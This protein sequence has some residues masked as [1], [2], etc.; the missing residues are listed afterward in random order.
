MSQGCAL[1]IKFQSLISFVSLCE[2]CPPNLVFHFCWG[3][4][5]FATLR[6]VEAFYSKAKFLLDEQNILTRM[7][8]KLRQYS[9]K[10]FCFP[11]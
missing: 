11:Y 2:T 7:Q 8:V 6:L 1:N 4:Y 9:P 5:I 10:P 3:L